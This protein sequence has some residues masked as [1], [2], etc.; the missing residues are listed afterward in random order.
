MENKIP[1]Y[2][3]FMKTYNENEEVVES[4]KSKIET[5][6]KIRNDKENKKH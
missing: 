4:Y 3:E 6:E 2:E 1:T 5:Q